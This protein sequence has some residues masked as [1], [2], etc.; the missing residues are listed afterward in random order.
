MKY[1]IIR[2]LLYWI[3]RVTK[4]NKTFYNL[5]FKLWK[6]YC[7]FSIWRF[8]EKNYVGRT[9]KTRYYHDAMSWYMFEDYGIKWGSK[10]SW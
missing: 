9:Y 5:S 6:L 2:E 1:W 8:E 4:R 3:S 10:L 7:K